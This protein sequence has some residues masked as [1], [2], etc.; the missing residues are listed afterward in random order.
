VEQLLLRTGLG[1]DHTLF[2]LVDS[3]ATAAAIARW[4]DEGN[5]EARVVTEVAPQ[6]FGEDL[7][8]CA[9]VAERVRKAGTTILFLG[10][11]APKSELFASRYRTQLG[12]CWA[13]CIGQG[14]KIALGL[15]PTPPRLVVRLRLE[16]AW[17]VLQE[18]RRLCG[19]YAS[20][21]I[22]FGAAVL[23]DIVWPARRDV[24]P[25]PYSSGKS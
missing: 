13:L 22:G 4:K 20:S 17:R 15:V 10:L 24:L 8:I 19:R 2:F 18:P 7:A 3:S 5:I 23:R 21:F 1:P 16:W 12:G 6:C 25:L 14:I 11:G 9:A